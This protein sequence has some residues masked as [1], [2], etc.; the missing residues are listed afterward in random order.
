MGELLLLG[1]CGRRS[2]PVCLHRGSLIGAI[3]ELEL[4]CGWIPASHNTFQAAQRI[5][6]E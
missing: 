2:M 1:G 5:Y 3:H 6:L 4:A